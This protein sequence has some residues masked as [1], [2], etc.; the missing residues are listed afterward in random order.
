MHPS[1]GTWYKLRAPDPLHLF[2]LVQPVLTALWLSHLSTP[3]WEAGPLRVPPRVL[4]A[5]AGV[6]V[7]VAGVVFLFV[8]Q[9]LLLFRWV[10]DRW[11]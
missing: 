10:V 4:G 2:V 7:G 9:G 11:A 5:A 6:A 8:V 1:L 3:D